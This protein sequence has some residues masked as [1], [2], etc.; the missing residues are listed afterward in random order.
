MSM[1]QTFR[2][3]TR[4]VQPKQQHWQEN[5]QQN[6]QDKWQDYWLPELPIMAEPGELA[7]GL[8]WFSI[9]LGLAQLVAPRSMQAGTEQQS[10]Q[11]SLEPWDYR[12]S[13]DDG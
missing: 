2:E 13:S 4:A 8:G 7:S 5:D 3:Q 10:S 1:Q 11:Q 12:S 9:A 6:R